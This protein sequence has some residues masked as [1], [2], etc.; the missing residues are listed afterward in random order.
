MESSPSSEPFESSYDSRKKDS[1]E[2]TKKGSYTL[3]VPLPADALHGG[4]QPKELN[5]PP[6]PERI[7]GI[8]PIFAKHEQ[9][10]KPAEQPSTAEHSSQAEQP[11]THPALENLSDQLWETFDTAPAPPPDTEA[12]R[13]AAAD[14]HNLEKIFAQPAA[15]LPAGHPEAAKGE[16]DDEEEKDDDTDDT[17]LIIRKPKPTIQERPAARPIVEAGPQTSERAWSTPAA[18]GADEWHESRTLHINEP[19]PASET[20]PPDGTSLP[21]TEAIAAEVAATEPDEAAGDALERDFARPAAELPA[22]HPEAFGEPLPPMTEQ[23]QFQDIMQRTDFTEEF[24]QQTAAHTAP[25]PNMV[26]AAS[27]YVPTMEPSAEA[28]AAAM[29]TVSAADLRY[30]A[31][32]PNYR[33]AAAAAAA[34]G[35]IVGGASA[36]GAAFGVGRR[37]ETSQVPA[38]PQQEYIPANPNT[39]TSE[40]QPAAYRQPE[41]PVPLT[42]EQR[43]GL[44]FTEQQP[45]AA[46]MPRTE[47]QPAHAPAP[48]QPEQSAAAVPLAPPEAMQQEY[49][50]PQERKTH[51]VESAWHR[52]EVE[53]G[54]NRIVEGQP[55][56]RALSEEKR[57]ESAPPPPPMDDQDQDDQNQQAAGSMYQQYLPGNIAPMIDSGQIGASHELTSGEIDDYH[58]LEAP[59]RNAVVTALTSP[60]LWV[61]IVLLL[62]TFFASAFL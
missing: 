61:G 30:I 43:T 1:K 26:E 18:A 11:H 45:Q 62:L 7:S 33:T 37:S 15:E 29:P 39:Y 24:V 17:T 8:L 31:G 48:Q 22:N 60:L 41:Q 34:E 12:D 47:T 59:H 40:Q 46:A 54:T 21:S 32:M 19:V 55:E 25:A 44:Q 9:P 20:L 4:E 53:N 16:D 35:A 38:L 51:T 13:R 28:P 57:A 56:G 10:P 42:N 52:V 27:G 49:A 23:E 58:R 36:A 50:H 6:T 3:R 5:R 2:P 14:A